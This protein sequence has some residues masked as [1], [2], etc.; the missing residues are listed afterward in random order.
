MQHITGS[1]QT[2]DG[3]KIHTESWLPEGEVRAVVVISHG[4]G[5]H[6][7]RYGHVAARLVEAGYAVYGLDHRGHGQS[8]GVRA[9]YETF[10]LPVENLKQYIDSVKAEQPN[11]ALFLY[12]HSLGSLIALAY[13]LKYQSELAGLIISGTPLEVEATQPALLITAA[14]VLNGLIPEGGDHP[15][16]EQ[17][18]LP[19]FSSGASV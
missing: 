13:T 18:S 7:G 2:P 12:G 19:R 15:T 10:D 3:L 8:E 9:Y 5:E 4:I 11:K 17:L 16:C 1:F 14:N 6:I